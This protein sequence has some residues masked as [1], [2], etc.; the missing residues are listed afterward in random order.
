MKRQERAG[1]VGLDITDGWTGRKIR[2]S[3]LL[4]LL[5]TVEEKVFLGHATVWYQTERIERHN[6]TREIE[7]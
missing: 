3:N 4:G 1:G 5:D 7:R 2:I 6:L